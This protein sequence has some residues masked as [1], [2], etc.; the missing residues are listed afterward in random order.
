M[1]SRKEMVLVLAVTVL[2]FLAGVLV[3]SARM[4]TDFIGSLFQQHLM[5][6]ILIMVFA[7]LLGGAINHFLTKDQLA[8]TGDA[9][10]QSFLGRCLLIG[11]GASFLVPLFLQMISS[12]LIKSPTDQTTFVLN[13]YLVFAGFCLVA[14]I[15]SKAFIQTISDRV[16]KEAQ[17]ARKDAKSA[18]EEAL[19]AKEG[20]KGA[21]EAVH[22]VEAKTDAIVAAK[23]E[24][25][26]EERPPAV[27][28]GLEANGAQILA[29][30]AVPPLSDMDR[31]VLK[32]L[33]G[34][35]YT[36]RSLGGI[37][38]ETK[39]DKAVLNKGI[40]DLMDRG[41]VGQSVGKSG[42]V[43]WYA[44]EEGRKLSKSLRM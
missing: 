37:A 15:S 28:A 3:G 33:T 41:L 2:A 11:V 34:G 40:T 4:A 23:T 10:K 42:A 36:F 21:T 8:V 1:T 26:E 9:T 12:E 13:N 29:A 20:A 18:K 14:A 27:D 19:A 17:E 16:L 32:A 24:P 6:L 25:N 22:A 30:Q 38:E 43:R 31:A 7:G 39:K 35:E 44:T 5:I